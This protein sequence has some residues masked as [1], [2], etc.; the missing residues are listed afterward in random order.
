MEGTRIYKVCPESHAQ[1][2][3]ATTAAKSPRMCDTALICRSRVAQIPQVC[4]LRVTGLI[5]MSA[6]RDRMSPQFENQP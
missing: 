6:N 5:R 1:P 4:L 3:L 2:A